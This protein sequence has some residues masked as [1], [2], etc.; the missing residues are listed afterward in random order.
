[1]KYEISSQISVLN[2]RFCKFHV[3]RIEFEIFQKRTAK[4]G[5]Y[6]DIFEVHFRNLGHSTK[7]ETEFENEIFQRSSETEFENE[8]FQPGSEF[9]ILKLRFL[10]ETKNEILNLRFSN[11]IKK[12]I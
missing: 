11:E 1:M 12:S 3:F 7:T 4:N 10:N 6:D 9:E 2:L 5:S 8:I